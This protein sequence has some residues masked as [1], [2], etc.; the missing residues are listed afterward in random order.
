MYDAVTWM[1]LAIVV[2]GLTA[3]ATQYGKS[4]AT[5]QTADVAS[6]GAGLAA[7]LSEANP[8]GLA[9]LPVKAAI[10][11]W[12]DGQPCDVGRQ[13]EK[14]INTVTYAAVGNNIALMIGLNPIAGVV[15][16]AGS[17]LAYRYNN[18]ISCGYRRLTDAEY[19]AMITGLVRDG[20][21]ADQDE[22]KRH[23]TRDITTDAI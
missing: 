12:A 23:W 20:I 19:D 6:T 2:M 14:G 10:T 8:L 16:G 3:C 9:L 21:Y 11:Y 17:F 18:K 1:L 15:V 7:G 13:A 22:A 5:A 4:I